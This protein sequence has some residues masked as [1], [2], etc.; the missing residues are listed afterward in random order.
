MK[1]VDGAVKTSNICGGFNP[2]EIYLLLTIYGKIIS[3]NFMTG[4]EK[5]TKGGDVCSFYL[6]SVLDSPCRP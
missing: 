3:H 1:T 6:D 4:N 5:K 2:K